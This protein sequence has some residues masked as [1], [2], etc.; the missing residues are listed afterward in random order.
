MPN[1][2]LSIDKD[3]YR[4]ARRWCLERD[5]CVSHVVKTF[6]QDLV[7]LDPSGVPDL[8]ALAALF[9]APGPEEIELMRDA[10]AWK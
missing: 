2:T 8:P 1:I 10:G 9:D 7:R 6:L 3:T 4:A 5:T